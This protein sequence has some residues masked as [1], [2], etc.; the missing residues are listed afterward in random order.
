MSILRFIIILIPLVTTAC[1]T[2]SQALPGDATLLADVPFIK[3]DDFQCGPSALATVINYWDIKVGTNRN[4][5]LERIVE[6]IYSPTAK[7]VLG[8]DLEQYA[9]K[10]GFVTQCYSGNIEDIKRRIDEGIPLIL[11]VDYGISSYQRNHFLV[12]TGYT[13]DAII[14]NSGKRENEII[15]AERLKKIWKKTDF[16]TLLIRPSS[17]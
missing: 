8:M 6:D 13:G 12:T 4:I 3:Q 10:L 2:M 1:G 17:F 16:W 5:S 15:P 11:F 7:G 14:V 9:R